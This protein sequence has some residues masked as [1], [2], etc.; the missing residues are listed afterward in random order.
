MVVALVCSL[1]SV[2]VQVVLLVRLEGVFHVFV[3]IFA[4]IGTSSAGWK[5]LRLSPSPVPT[6]DIAHSHTFSISV[7][8][9]I[10]HLF[11][12]SIDSLFLVTF[13]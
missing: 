12:R 3:P 5:T 10:I 6:T 4:E 7:F 1:C 9:S 8:S 2:V 11:A 13:A